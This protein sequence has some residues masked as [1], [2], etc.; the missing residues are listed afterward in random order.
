MTRPV[1]TIDTHALYWY[2]VADPQ[3]SA[4]A[5]AVFTEA[6]QGRAEL[7]LNPIVLAE[8]CYILRKFRLDDDFAA[9]VTS[10]EG[11]PMYRLEPIIWDALPV[12]R[13][14]RDP[15]DARSSDRHS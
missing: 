3:L 10:I 4:S 14:S 5:E 12:S 6:E 13:L 15:R 7:V 8:F 1:Y 11:N 2:E 9:F